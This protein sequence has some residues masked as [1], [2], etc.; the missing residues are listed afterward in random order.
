MSQDSRGK[1]ENRYEIRSG[2]WGAFFHDRF[3]D[4]DLALTEVC[5]LLNTFTPETVEDI[6]LEC[7]RPAG[8]GAGHWCYKCSLLAGLVR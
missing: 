8:E 2:K 1:K 3:K 4:K 6:C 7:H 5:A